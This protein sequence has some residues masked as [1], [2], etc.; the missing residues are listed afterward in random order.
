MD[1]YEIVAGTNGQ[2]A[3]Y[4][5]K[6]LSKTDISFGPCRLYDSPK[7]RRHLDRKLDRSE[8]VIPSFTL[9][10]TI[11]LVLVSMFCLAH[12]VTTPFTTMPPTTTT[13]TTTGQQT[14]TPIPPTTPT[15]TPTIFQNYITLISAYLWQSRV[16]GNLLLSALTLSLG[17][18]FLTTVPALSL[19]AGSNYFKLL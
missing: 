6:R 9:L 15:P 13:L 11:L 3:L 19:P 4:C 12:V 10:A 8:R 1:R 16:R 14:F 17:R 18:I 5:L 2:K 7:L